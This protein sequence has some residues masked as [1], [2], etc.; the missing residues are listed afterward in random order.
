[1]DGSKFT[2]ASS[3]KGKQQT[4]FHVVVQHGTQDLMLGNKLACLLHVLSCALYAS[5]F[6]ILTILKLHA[7]FL[8]FC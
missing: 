8:D 5:I 7:N 1:M 2:D 6:Y 3:V 4:I